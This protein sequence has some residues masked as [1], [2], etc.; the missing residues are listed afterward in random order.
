MLAAAYRPLKAHGASSSLGGTTKFMTDIIATHRYNYAPG[1]IL[2]IVKN[3]NKGT[4]TIR[5]RPAKE[6]EK[7]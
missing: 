6:N 7:V 2:E 5:V 4:V 3:L 1:L